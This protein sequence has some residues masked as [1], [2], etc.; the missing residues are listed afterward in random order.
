[1]DSYREAQAQRWLRKQLSTTALIGQ[2][3]PLAT[4]IPEPPVVETPSLIKKMPSPLT[5][6]QEQSISIVAIDQTSFDS[7]ISAKEFACGILF[8]TIEDS[9]T[10]IVDVIYELPVDLFIHEVLRDTREEMVIRLSRLMGLQPVGVIITNNNEL[11]STNLIQVMQLK[12]AITHVLIIVNTEGEARAVVPTPRCYSA[13]LSPETTLNGQTVAG[14]VDGTLLQR[15]IAV[16]KRAVN[17]IIHAGFYR[18]HRQNHTPTFNDARA[19][20]I[21]RRDKAKISQL[22]LQLADYHLILFIASAMGEIT[23]ERV[24]IA[25]HQEDDEL[26]EDLVQLILNSSADL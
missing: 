7:L 19:F 2:E 13:K 3:P 21:A 15:K 11:I 5:P 17:T 9:H 4:V 6:E 18:L 22:H 10:V 12:S 14:G 23:A 25:I 20:I 26:V 24:I 1:M 8:G 16:V